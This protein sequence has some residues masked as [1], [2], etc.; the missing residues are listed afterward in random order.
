MKKGLLFFLLIT[1]CMTQQEYYA[2]HTYGSVNCGQ[3]QIVIRQVDEKWDIGPV[4]KAEC[5]GKTYLC[6]WGVN[7]R[8]PVCAEER[9]APPPKP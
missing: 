7:E 4:W 9:K 3:G 1:G 5:P 6:R 8:R 2:L